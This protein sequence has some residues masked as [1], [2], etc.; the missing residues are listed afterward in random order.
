MQYYRVD[1]SG[2]PI[3]ILVDNEDKDPTV[4]PGWGPEISFFDPIYDFELKA[5]REGM[6]AEDIDSILNRPREATEI[7]KL[8]EENRMNA[9]AIME[10]AEIILGG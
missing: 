3:E 4:I 2:K 6:S 5:W 1:E 7:E 10:L 9:M 8:N